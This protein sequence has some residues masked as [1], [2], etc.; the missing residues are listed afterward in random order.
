MRGQLIPETKMLL[1]HAALDTE[2]FDKLISFMRKGAWSDISDGHGQGSGF[3]VWTT[4]EKALR[5]ISWLRSGV[6]KIYYPLLVQF[7]EILDNKNWNLDYELNTYLIIAFLRGHWN[8]FKKIPDDAVKIDDAHLIVSKCKKGLFK[9]IH[10]ETD[11]WQF[12]SGGVKDKESSLLEGAVMGKIFDYLEANYPS[13][14]EYFESRVF[15]GL[16]KRGIGIKYVG[17]KPLKVHSFDI[18]AD[19][20]WLSE[21]GSIKFVESKGIKL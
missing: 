12:N 5:H 9:N 8:L 7:K 4:R 3:F 11:K 19:E 6:K 15:T 20:R 1:W 14:T 2:N 13:E 10:F 21:S 18:E 16:A 17:H